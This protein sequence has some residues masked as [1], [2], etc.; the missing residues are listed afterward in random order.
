MSS[1]NSLSISANITG[2]RASHGLRLLAAISIVAGVGAGL[3][4]YCARRA[5]DAAAAAAAPAAL[6]PMGCQLCVKLV[7][8]SDCVRPVS[9]AAVGTTVSGGSDDSVSAHNSSA[10]AFHVAE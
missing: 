1:N 10:E 8:W 4:Y 5:Q 3:Y 9:S 2:S 6:T 7:D